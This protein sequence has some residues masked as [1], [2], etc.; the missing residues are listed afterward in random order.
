MFEMENGEVKPDPLEEL[1][2]VLELQK[3]HQK[4]I[5][6]QSNNADSAKAFE[7]GNLAVRRS[8]H[9]WF[10]RLEATDTTTEGEG[11]IDEKQVMVV[12]ILYDEVVFHLHLLKNAQETDLEPLKS[13]TIVH[14]KS[15]LWNSPRRCNCNPRVTLAPT[16]GNRK[17]FQRWTTVIKRT[18]TIASKKVFSNRATGD[19]WADMPGIPDHKFL[20][21]S[22]GNIQRRTQLESIERYG[23]H[24]ARREANAAEKE[25]LVAAREEKLKKKED[26]GEGKDNAN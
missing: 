5:D 21:K 14:W 16:R 17:A 26:K 22:P 2:S 12:R 9:S 4:N 25:R 3:A 7:D 6:E 10:E 8:V 24:L 1:I 20:S 19:L 13:L 11:V 23:A 18:W 15:S